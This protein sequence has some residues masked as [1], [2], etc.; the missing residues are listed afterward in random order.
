[1]KA[2]F[3][4]IYVMSATDC[5]SGQSS[6]SECSEIGDCPDCSMDDD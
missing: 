5:N 3:D 1:M 2:Y 4:E 6:G